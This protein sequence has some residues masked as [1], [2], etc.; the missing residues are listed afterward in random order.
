MNNKPRKQR[1]AVNEELYTRIKKVLDM[2]TLSNVQIGKLFNI[3][4]NVVGRIKHSADY[5][6]YGRMKKAEAILAQRRAEEKA[7]R[8]QEAKQAYQE[9]ADEYIEKAKQVI[10]NEE[11]PQINDVIEELKE[12]NMKLGQLVTI[13]E[14]EKNNERWEQRN[15]YRP[16]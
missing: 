16:F 2:N 10:K 9:A 15:N 14:T 6:D 1:V 8:N 5:N 13:W 4:D 12:I 11:D 3:S 7:K